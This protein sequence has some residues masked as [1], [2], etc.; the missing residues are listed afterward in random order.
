MGGNAARLGALLGGPV[1]AL[2]LLRRER[3]R[4]ARGRAVAAAGAGAV[5]DLLAGQRPAGGLPRGPGQPVGERL[6]LRPAAGRAAAPGRRLRRPPGAHRDRPHGGPLGG[7]LGRAARDD[8]ARLGAPAGRGAQ[9][10]LLRSSGPLSA[11]ELHAWLLRTGGLAGRAAATP[12]STTPAGPRRGCCAGPP[13][14]YLREVWRS[15]ALAPVRGLGSAAAALG[16]GG[17]GSVS[18][19]R[20]DLVAAASR[21]LPAAA[22]LHAP[23]GSSL[24]ARLR[25]TRARGLDAACSRRA[26][27]AFRARHPLLARAACSTHGPRCT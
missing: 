18:T 22:S 16:P 14:P 13:P 26:P 20:A 19:D 4:F 3:G 7:P 1:A 10:A 6:L 23:T 21:G 27:G 15:A 24:R 12:R 11:A 25:G 8:R 9:R 17:L 2:V 5:A